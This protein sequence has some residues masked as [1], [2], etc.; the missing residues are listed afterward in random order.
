MFVGNS[1]DKTTVGAPTARLERC[2][3]MV[4]QKL[5][6]KVT[7]PKKERG[8]LIKKLI[9]EICQGIIM[10][11]LPHALKNPFKK[12]HHWSH[13][14]KPIQK[15]HHWSHRSKSIQK[16]E[17]D[18]REDGEQIRERE[19]S[20]EKMREMRDRGERVEIKYIIF[21]TILATVQFYV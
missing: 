10:T 11:F 21:D 15:K 4:N 19:K 5:K 1:R 7:S 16:N 17:R 18:E 2:G 20:T 12:H 14:S 6:A 9:E 8:L 13:R 3:A